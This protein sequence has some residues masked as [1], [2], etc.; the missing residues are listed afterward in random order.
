MGPTSHVPQDLLIQV[1]PPSLSSKLVDVNFIARLI[2]ADRSL[3][4]IGFTVKFVSFLVPLA[5]RALSAF[6]LNVHISFFPADFSA[7]EVYYGKASAVLPSKIQSI[8]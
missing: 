2:D 3:T 5:A 6:F 7:T 1:F 8:R 4:P